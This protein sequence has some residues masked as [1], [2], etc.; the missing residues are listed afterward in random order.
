MRLTHDHTTQAVPPREGSRN[1]VEVHVMSRDLNHIL[2]QT[3]GMGGAAGPT[4]D[5]G[6]FRL[7]D[8]DVVL[9]CTNGLTDV[10]ADDAL[11]HVL[12]SHQTPDQ[13]CRAVVDLAAAAGGTDD[14]TAL[15]A[16]YRI[17]ASPE[18]RAART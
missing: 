12:A 14:T 16:H 3:I 18:P 6:S 15:V 9:L 1:L 4:I 7:A 13:K 17:P 5:L 10:V 11:A 8:S 2:T